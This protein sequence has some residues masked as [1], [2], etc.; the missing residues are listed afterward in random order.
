MMR[1][2][3]LSALS[4]K[5]SS[6]K[7]EW[8]VRISRYSFPLYVISTIRDVYSKKYRCNIRVTFNMEN[9]SIF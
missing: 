7:C 5:N 2:I 8:L 6:V 1:I 4:T 3:F 9:L